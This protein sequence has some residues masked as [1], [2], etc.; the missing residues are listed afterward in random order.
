MKRILCYFLLCSLILG[1]IAGCITDPTETPQL[2][3]GTNPPSFPSSQDNTTQGIAPPEVL[4]PD[5]DWNL[6]ILTGKNEIVYYT[7][8]VNN[9]YSFYIYS[10]EPQ[11]VHGIEVTLPISY[12]YSVKVQECTLR[13]I[14]DVHSEM[15]DDERNFFPDS[16]S[17][18]LYMAW[19]G[20]DFQ[21][22]VEL[23]KTWK[24][25]Y[26]QYEAG[27]Y[28]DQWLNGEITWEEYLQFN[29]PHETAL[30]EYDAYLGAQWGDYLTLT[31][32]DLPQ[33][34]VYKV[35][36]LFS[37]EQPIET[38]ESFTEIEV[39]IGEQ[40]CRQQIGRVTLKGK[41]E[42]P[43]PFDW[44]EEWGGLDG[45]MGSGGFVRPYND[46]VNCIKVLYRFTAD[47]YK[48]LERITFAN[49]GQRIDR[50]WVEVWPAAG[51]RFT[52]QWDMSEPLEVYPGD[53]VTVYVS[54]QD[55]GM[56]EPGYQSMVYSFLEYT[57][58][59]A[60]YCK[61]AQCEIDP[62]Q[63]HYVWYAILVQQIDLEYYYRDY[64][65]L[66]NEPWRYDPE[67]D[68]VLYD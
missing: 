43:A 50:V 34:Y 33:F 67:E 19:L 37:W 4:V 25:L 22:L 56:E 52:T 40:L 2:S 53:Q 63:Q 9:I 3:T 54:Y 46:E 13:G 14:Q 38:E 17:Y 48:L 16:F 65:Y 20:K 49:P 41:L 31:A 60:R 61:Y 68:P 44:H 10:K 66:F 39:T 35:T 64:Y 6:Y 8:E 47:R 21:K 58:D 15:R 42:A 23:R 27:S 1:C 18:P 5:V 12:D 11:D 51:S 30:A 36:I 59:G 32:E 57:T 26:R 62:S 7:S 29:Q 45:I 24:D 28:H 55:E